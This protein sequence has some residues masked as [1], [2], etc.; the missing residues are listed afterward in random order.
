MVEFGVVG[1]VVVVVVVVEDP[2][3]LEADVAAKVGE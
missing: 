1:C 2:R 3:R